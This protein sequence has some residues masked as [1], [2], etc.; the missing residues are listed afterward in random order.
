V[1]A[2]QRNVTLPTDD[3]VLLFQRLELLQKRIGHRSEKLA[4]LA[5]EL[6]DD[7][8]AER[9]VARNESIEGLAGDL[10]HS[11][12][13]S[14]E[15]GVGEDGRRERRELPLGRG[16]INGVD[17]GKG[18]GSCLRRVDHVAFEAGG[19]GHVVEE[20]EEAPEAKSSFAL[21][22]VLAWRPAEKAGLAS[23]RVMRGRVGGEKER[24]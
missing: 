8:V 2:L 9:R 3:R 21:D 14:L 6:H 23:V 22:R 18:R 1:N 10:R 16:E 12:L 13:V 20:G 24:E 5:V 4:V 17:V 7:A 19:G 15:G 11:E